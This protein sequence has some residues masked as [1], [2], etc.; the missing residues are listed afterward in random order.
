MAILRLLLRGA[1]RWGFAAG[2]PATANVQDVVLS[3]SPS[4]AGSLESITGACVEAP[5]SARDTLQ[6]G[7]HSETALHAVCPI[8]THCR[9][10]T[11]QLLQSKKR[12]RK[13]QL[14]A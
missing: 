11:W 5:P 1:I 12:T 7:P 10:T 2:S 3:F 14:G 9:Q 4:H 8:Q 6:R 13:E